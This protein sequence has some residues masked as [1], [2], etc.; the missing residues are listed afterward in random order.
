MS[1]LPPSTKNIFGSAE[2]DLGALGLAD[3]SYDGFTANGNPDLEGGLLEEDEE[4]LLDW[5]D[6]SERKTG[7]VTRRDG[8]SVECPG[9]ENDAE[10]EAI[11]KALKV[12]SVLSP[13][14][15]FVLTLPGLAFRTW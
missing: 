6:G 8:A 5:G 3:D 2:D 15:F 9:M 14:S 11:F 1:R 10:Y 12:G 7:T 4:A 13:L